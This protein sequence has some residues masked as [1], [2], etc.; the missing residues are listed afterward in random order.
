MTVLE[1]RQFLDGFPD[2]MRVATSGRDGE[3]FVQRLEQ[4][5][6]TVSASGYVSECYWV[7]THNPDEDDPL[8]AV[9]I[10]KT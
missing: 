9:L 7:E 8:E 2:D 3:A 1:M 5:V 10:L 4:A 6:C